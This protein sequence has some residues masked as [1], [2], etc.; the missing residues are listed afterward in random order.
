MEKFIDILKVISEKHLIPAVISIAVAILCVTLAPDFLEM[1]QKVG[2]F[3]YGVFC[4]CIMFLICELTKYLHNKLK[5][6]CAE[7]E[8]IK[9]EKIY[10]QKK[11][12][13]EENEIMENL[14]SFVDS[15]S[16]QDRHYLKI[17]LDNKNEPIEVLGVPHHYGLL[18]NQNI[19]VCTEKRQECGINHEK[20]IEFDG[21]EVYQSYDIAFRM[22]K[23]P[24][25][26]YRLKDDFY[27]E[28]KFSNE[29][30]H[31]ISHFG[32]EEN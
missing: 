22:Y 1:N 17:F 3:L 14:W 29:K 12:E 32:T 31:R 30:Y 13:E 9:E 23:S 25:K 5:S 20:K 15:L 24:T 7:K 28:L 6:R 11:N 27:N 18:R 21:R 26:L 2:S 16:V 10:R 19:V 8:K 4:F